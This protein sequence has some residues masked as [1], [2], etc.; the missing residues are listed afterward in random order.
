MKKKAKKVVKKKFNGQT[1]L[2]KLPKNEGERLELMIRM[3]EKHTTDSP[4]HQFL[5]DQATRLRAEL[6]A[7][8]KANPA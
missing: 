6:A 7:W 4:S 5:R 2:D 3:T 1:M 8:K